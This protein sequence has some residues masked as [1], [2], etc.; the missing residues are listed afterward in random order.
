MVRFVLEEIRYLKNARLS[1]TN[2]R[3]L[4][5]SEIQLF[6]AFNNKEKGADSS[7]WDPICVVFRS[8]VPADQEHDVHNPPDP[9]PSQG[10][11][12][13][14]GRSGLPETKSIQTEESQED[15]VE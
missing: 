3:D 4:Q 8:Q 2:N 6:R 14:H 15:R 13:A 12:L 9:Q 1:H 5:F 7:I 10:Q 11:E